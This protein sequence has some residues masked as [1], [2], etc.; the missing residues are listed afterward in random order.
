MVTNYRT[1]LFTAWTAGI[2]L[3]STLTIRLFFFFFVFFF[4]ALHVSL[5]INIPLVVLAT[6]FDE[7]TQAQC[8]YLRKKYRAIQNINPHKYIFFSRPHRQSKKQKT[9]WTIHQFSAV[10]F[11][12]FIINW[13]FPSDSWSYYDCIHS[14]IY[15]CN[16][17][18]HK[19]VYSFR[20]TQYIWRLFAV[21]G[22]RDIKCSID[23]MKHYYLYT[24]IMCFF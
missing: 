3:C 13:R 6:A 21:R 1:S 2:T 15:M 10:N 17:H 19:I 12:I 7:F 24:A 4:H 22:L 9:T 5:D 14:Y 16:A 20:R 23:C 8:L 18:I 11:S